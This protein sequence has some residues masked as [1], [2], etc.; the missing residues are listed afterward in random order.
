MSK[1]IVVLDPGHGG[2]DPGAV[3]TETRLQEKDVVLEIGLEARRLLLEAGCFV[4]MTRDKDKFVSLSRRAEISSEAK[5][6]AFVSMHCNAA[7]NPIAHGFECFS[8]PRRNRSDIL[9]ARL[10]HSFAWRHPTRKSR[11]AKEAN[12]TVIGSGN[13]APSSLFE[14]EFIHNEQGDEF[15]SK[16]EN[17]ESCAEATA[18][19]ILAFLRIVDKSPSV[20]VD[21]TPDPTATIHPSKEMLLASHQDVQDQLDKLG[22]LINALG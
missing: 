3:N 9:S 16:R 22:E 5:A 2:H 4:I 19:G 20:P 8:T 13:T 11:G 17:I 14:Y 18:A 10:L 6:D 21:D 7:E 15:F 12:F 1:P